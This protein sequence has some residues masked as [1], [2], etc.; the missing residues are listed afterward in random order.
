MCGI[1]S[2]LGTKSIDIVDLNNLQRHRGADF[3]SQ[4]DDDFAL[5]GHQGLYIIDL[6]ERLDQPFEKDGLVIVFN[7]E[8]Y[9]YKVLKQQLRKD[10]D[11]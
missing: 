10:F 11:I 1:I 8:I 7:G 5:F 9:N 4:W 2:C 6:S 3:Q